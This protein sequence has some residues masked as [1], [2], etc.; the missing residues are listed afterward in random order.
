MF[1]KV[2]ELISLS[3]DGKFVWSL[4]FLN[5]EKSQLCSRPC[6]YCGRAAE[7]SGSVT[8]QNGLFD[9]QRASSVPKFG[10]SYRGWPVGAEAGDLWSSS[11]QRIIVSSRT[12]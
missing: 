8:L 11:L 3:V 12:R 5:A 7:G 1:P 10:F 2:G 4:K 9:H 6:T